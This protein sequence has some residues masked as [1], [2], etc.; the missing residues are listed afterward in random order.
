MA[1]SDEEDSDEK[2]TLSYFKQNLNTFSTS[3]LRK[4]A[5]VLLD[6]IREMKDEKDLVNNNLDI[7]QD[8]KIAL[9]AKISDIKSQMLVL[10]A[11]NLEL[12]KRMKGVTNKTFKGKNEASSL[13]LELENKLHTAEMKTNVALDRN[14]ELERDM[15]RVKEELKNLSNGPIPLRFLQI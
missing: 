2:V 4:L 3:K 12:K 14:L 8:G 7:S 9:V 6:L 11:E 10:E 13:Q 5:V 1:K 15:V